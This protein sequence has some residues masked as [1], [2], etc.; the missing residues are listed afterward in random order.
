[1]LNQK[2]IQQLLALHYVYPLPLNKLQ[3]LLC[4]IQTLHELQFIS[5]K[6]LAQILQIQLQTAQI[7]KV[8]YN[9][10]AN[11]PFKVYYE[12]H[13]MHAIPF[14]SENYPKSLLQ[15]SDAPTVIYVQGHIDLLQRQKIAC[16]GSRNSTNYSSIALQSILP[17]L[18][19]EQ[20]VIVSGLAKGADTLAH[21]MTIE[22]GGSTIAVVGHGFAHLYPKE[23][24]NLA[25]KIV[26]EHLLLTEYP[27]YM[28]PKKWHFP[29]RNRI[30]SGLSCALVVTEAAMKSGT[31]ITT[32]HALEHGKDVFVVPGP[33]HS[34][35]SKGTNN[36]LKE[37]A[38]PVWNG[39]QIVEELQMFQMKY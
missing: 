22:L 37:G 9:K 5:A 3:R 35:Q 31:L 30:I 8:N 19:A 18:I 26:S 20:Y 13:N 17:P 24:K 10:A 15:L 11:T 28:G 39:Q 27:P 7:L 33:I 23:N 25:A 21:Q 2:E 14:T 6:E 1:M 36:L 16:I 29:M 32:D 38:I 12:Q 4:A 34:E